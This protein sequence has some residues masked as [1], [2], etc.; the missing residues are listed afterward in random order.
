M[1]HPIGYYREF[2]GDSQGAVNVWNAAAHNA[3]SGVPLKVA[4]KGVMRHQHGDVINAY[5][6]VQ[7]AI[8]CGLFVREV[9]VEARSLEAGRNSESLES[10]LE[11]VAPWLE[12]TATTYWE[13]GRLESG[14]TA[15]PEYSEFDR[16]VATSI[17]LVESLGYHDVRV[18]RVWDLILGERFAVSFW[19]VSRN[20][21]IIVMRNSRLCEVEMNLQS[22]AKTESQHRQLK[23]RIHQQQLEG[24]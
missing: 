15:S 23:A 19:D 20:S 22:W 8:D 1:A 10:L 7:E 17:E 3:A 11:L 13:Q 21:P 2:E 6:R 16:V 4:I 5:R 18:E 24:V 12:L 9:D 14:V